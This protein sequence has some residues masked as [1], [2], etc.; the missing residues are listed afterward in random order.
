MMSKKCGEF[1]LLGAAEKKVSILAKLDIFVQ[2][3]D[4][5]HRKSLL[6]CTSLVAGSTQMMRDDSAIVGFGL[7]QGEADLEGVRLFAV[8]VDHASR[9]STLVFGVHQAM[10]GSIKPDCDSHLILVA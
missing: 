5:N 9:L 2:S 3:D 6:S 4:Q 7:D 1:N 10:K 8:A